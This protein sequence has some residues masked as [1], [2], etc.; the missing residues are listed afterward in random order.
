MTYLDSGVWM[1]GGTM[2]IKCKLRNGQTVDIEF[3]QNQLLEIQNDNKYPGQLY[4]NSIHVNPRSESESI[5]LAEL[6]KLVY[7]KGGIPW[8]EKSILME[9]I[10]YV[11]SEKYLTDLERLKNT[12]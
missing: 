4:V 11:E 3:V 8:M 6:K 9:K 1:D 5:L 12:E 2:T 7:A 10:E